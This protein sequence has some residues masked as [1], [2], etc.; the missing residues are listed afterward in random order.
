MTRLATALILCATLLTAAPVSAQQVVFVVR[1]AERAPSAAPASGRMMMADDPP[2]SA[3]GEQRAVKLTDMLAASGVKHIFTTEYKRTRQTA[4]P[5]AA[6]LAVTPLMAAAKDTASLVTAVKR[7]RGTV[8]IVG[9][10]NTIPEILK[11]LGVSD[12]VTIGD[13]DYDNLFVVF[14]SDAGKATL[15][16]LKF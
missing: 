1:H 9:H 14:R 3:A 15:V 8:L 12:A 4:A 16:R 11:Q 10:S 7:A 2:L 13:G 5:L 6:R